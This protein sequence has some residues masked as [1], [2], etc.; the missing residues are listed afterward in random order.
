V[1]GKGTEEG[2]K[3]GLGQDICSF[4]LQTV[5]KQLCGGKESELGER[6]RDRKRIYGRLRKDIFGFSFQT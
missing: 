2:R 5:Q 3:V 4:G 1:S 6:G